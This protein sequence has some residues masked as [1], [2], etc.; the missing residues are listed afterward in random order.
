MFDANCI[1]CGSENLADYPVCGP[2]S[3]EAHFP[4]RTDC[5][6]CA[7]VQWLD[8]QE[9]A[10]PPCPECDGTGEISHGVRRGYGWIEPSGVEPCPMCCIET[11]VPF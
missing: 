1:R 8:E 6:H 4:H 10:Q 7:W 9:P 2:C 3:H 11:E 5:A